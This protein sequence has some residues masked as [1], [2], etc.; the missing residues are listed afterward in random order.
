MSLN[1]NLCL[2]KRNSSSRSR[3]PR[4]QP[5]PVYRN[6]NL[7]G[8]VLELPATSTSPK[9]EARSISVSVTN[10]ILS[11]QLYPEN[12]QDLPVVPLDEISAISLGQ[13]LDKTDSEKQLYYARVLSVYTTLERTR[14]LTIREKAL[15][16]KMQWRSISL[17]GA[18]TAAS[19]I[20]AKQ[21]EYTPLSSVSITGTYDAP[22]ISH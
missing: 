4:P 3:S 10:S 6:G 22:C 11:S 7:V 21:S 16:T 20:E 15:A 2:Q 17:S 1:N 18:R 9:R 8:H 19:R 5:Q 13:T 14:P 12:W